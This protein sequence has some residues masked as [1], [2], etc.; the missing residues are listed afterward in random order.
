MA[1]QV[2]QEKEEIKTAASVMPVF[3]VGDTVRVFYKILEA[4]K[5][6]IQPYEGIV[7]SKRGEGS[8]KTFMVRR[9]GADS[10]GIERIFPLLSPNIESLK[11]IK[12]GRVRRAKLYYLR[13]KIGKAA[14]RIKE[15][16]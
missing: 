7:I 10:V 9:I 16:K 5:L 14:M 4:G 8:S 6:R 15:A 2:I 12:H 11:V 13:D 3:N 1:E